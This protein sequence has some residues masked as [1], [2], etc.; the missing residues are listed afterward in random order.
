MKTKQIGQRGEDLAL[1][2]LQEKGY[3]LLERNYRYGRAEIDLVMQQENLLVFIEV[4]YRK[5]ADFGYPEEFV[6]KK[7]R[8]ML[9]KAGDNF[10]YQQDWQHNIR[11]DIIAILPKEANEFEITHFEDAIY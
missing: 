4:K 2:F 11:Y 8:Q 1:A 6:G 3:Q 7:Q 9:L 5:N 10:I